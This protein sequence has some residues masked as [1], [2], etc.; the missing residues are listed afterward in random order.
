MMVTSRRANGNSSAL[1]LNRGDK[2]FPVSLLPLRR[3]LGAS[4]TGAT[5]QSPHSTDRVEAVKG[6]KY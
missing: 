6:K 4:N 1:S 2:S 5:L 3:A